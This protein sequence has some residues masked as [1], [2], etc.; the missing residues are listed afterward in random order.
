MLEQILKYQNIPLPDPRKD[1]IGA[2]KDTCGTRTQNSLA[3]GGIESIFVPFTSPFPSETGLITL[4]NNPTLIVIPK[5][6]A[7]PGDLTRF[8]RK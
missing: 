8:N 3:A 1:P 6:G 4:R 7:I 2:F 5:G